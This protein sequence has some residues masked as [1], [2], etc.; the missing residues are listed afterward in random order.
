MASSSL[1]PLTLSELRLKQALAVALL[2][3]PKAMASN[4]EIEKGPGLWET[5]GGGVGM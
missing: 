1:P 4:T 3:R 5:P 2:V